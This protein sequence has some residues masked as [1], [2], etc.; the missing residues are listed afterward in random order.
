MR[1]GTSFLFVPPM[2]L[3]AACGGGTGGTPEGDAGGDVLA[4]GDAPSGVD[5]G[6]QHTST[7][8]CAPSCGA[9][10]YCQEPLGPGICPNPSNGI[11]AG[12]FCP[13][14]CPGCPPLPPA[15]CEALPAACS[16]TPR[17]ACL[18]TACPGG[19]G[20]VAGTCTI[21]AD[22]DWVVSCLSC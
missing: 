19:C 18:L 7:H 17:C 2:L 4:L 20:A 3:V 1:F 14:G 16:G 15:S 6:V 8:E 21:D 5:A 10:K 12:G 11:D 22:G 13:Q 9:T